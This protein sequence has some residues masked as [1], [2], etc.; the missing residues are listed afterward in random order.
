[1]KYQHQKSS[2]HAILLVSVLVASLFILELEDIIIF[3]ALVIYFHMINQY[4]SFRRMW[5]GKV[6]LRK[7]LHP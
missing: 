3:K 4:F 1:M 2:S 6:K 5:I 7:V